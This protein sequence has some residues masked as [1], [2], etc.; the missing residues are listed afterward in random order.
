MSVAPSARWQR[1][2]RRCCGSDNGAVPFFTPW[3][4]M[5]AHG[6]SPRSR[7]AWLCRGYSRFLFVLRADDR[8]ATPR[9]H[10]EQYG[11]HWVRVRERP[12][13]SPHPARRVAPF[14]LRAAGTVTRDDEAP[15]AGPSC[16]PL[17][18]SVD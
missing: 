11:V 13:S 9:R 12:L 1:Q 17:D 18:I 16:R 4:E 5:I 2:Q 14:E 6:L 7:L 3:K 15:E 8:G 10:Y